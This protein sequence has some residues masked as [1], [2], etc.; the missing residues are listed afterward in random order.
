MKKH[1]FWELSYLFLQ[2]NS[3]IGPGFIYN[4]Y[5]YIYIY[6]YRGISM[7]VVEKFISVIQ[8]KLWNSCIK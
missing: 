8:L 5:I 6:I 3:D 7:N 4:V 2:M 1:D